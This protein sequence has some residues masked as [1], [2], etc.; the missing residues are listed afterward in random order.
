M[1]ENNNENNMNITDFN[2]IQPNN[3][4]QNNYQNQQPSINNLNQPVVNDSNTVE[5]I[6]QNTE[7]IEQ[8]VNNPQSIE[9]QYQQPTLEQS[10]Q[11]ENVFGM[12]IENN[13]I[14]ENN[15]TIET[16][17][18]TNNEVKEEQPKYGYASNEKAN[19]NK[20]ENAN[21]KFIIFLAILMLAVII[22]LP[23][24]NSLF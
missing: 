17:P 7:Y 12:P 1:M 14:E 4:N 18:L 24:L 10:V 13:L 20:D 5:P 2:S 16:N 21:I 15:N 11:Q 6:T 3:Y 8:P 19:L 9:Q 22:A 23:F